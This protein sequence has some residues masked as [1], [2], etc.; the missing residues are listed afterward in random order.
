MRNSLHCQ[1]RWQG[2]KPGSQW[3][4]SPCL[5]LLEPLQRGDRG[6]CHFL[7]HLGR[8]LKHIEMNHPL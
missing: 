3:V 6:K 1:L 5:R 4:S 8:S 2:D 7:A